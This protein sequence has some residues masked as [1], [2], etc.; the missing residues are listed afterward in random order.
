MKYGKV[1]CYRESKFSFLAA[2]DK[3]NRERNRRKYLI[4]S[5]LEECAAE[6]YCCDFIRWNI[7]N[8]RHPF[9]TIS[10]LLA[11]TTK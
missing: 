4:L 5:N 1:I 6:I 2:V 9:L 11:Q 3:F 7:S 10:H 8:V